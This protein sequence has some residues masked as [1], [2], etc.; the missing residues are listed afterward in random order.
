MFVF[1][2]FDAGRISQ[3]Q[4]Q[5]ARVYTDMEMW[6][7][8]RRRVLSGEISKRAACIEYE[9]HW[10][11][12]QKILSLAA[13]TNNVL[14]VSVSDHFELCLAKCRTSSDSV[15]HENTYRNKDR[16][17]CFGSVPPPTVAASR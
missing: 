17:Y 16:K 1:E 13:Q 2:E 7:E 10:D 14:F 8:V 9:I 4:Q 3:T 6:A 11:T 5:V 15:Q 12:L